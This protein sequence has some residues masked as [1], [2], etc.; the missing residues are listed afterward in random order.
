MNNHNTSADGWGIVNQSIRISRPARELYDI[1]RNLESLPRILTHV[2]SV[3]EL[4]DSRSHWVV[5]GPLGTDV[6]WDSVITQDVSG[7]LISWRSVEDAEVDNEGTVEFT[8]DPGSGSTL[9][10][11]RIAYRPPAGALGKT[12]AALFG[13][14]PDTQV[15][16][17]L[18]HFKEAVETDRFARSVP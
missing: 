10:D 1:W 7:K 9:M 3:R 15:R 13:K 17:D 16:D 2:K 4:T 12:V 14:N 6:E 5:E 11:V 8:A 18:A